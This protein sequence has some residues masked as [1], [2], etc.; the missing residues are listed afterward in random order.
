[1]RVLARRT[2]TGMTPADEQASE[3]FQSWPVGTVAYVEVKAARNPRQHR[4][5]FSL[6]NV[7]V[8]HGEFASVDG[9]LV[10]LKLA[11]GHVKEIRIKGDEMAIIPD[12]ISYANMGQ[13]QFESWF[14]AAVETV[15]SRW[16]PGWKSED[17]KRH[18]LDM[19]G[20]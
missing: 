8:E 7:M 13:I 15:C 17:L 3:Y 18:I 5:L 12:S 20:G 11:T 4:L 6:L 19:L 9:A 10:A 14:N 1:M 2:A 16:L